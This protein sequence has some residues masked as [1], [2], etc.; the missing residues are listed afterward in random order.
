[1][2]PAGKSV[3]FRIVSKDFEIQKSFPGR[4]WGVIAFSAIMSLGLLLS[5]G[6]GKPRVVGVVQSCKL[7]QNGYEL[8]LGSSNSCDYVLVQLRALLDAQGKIAIQRDGNA[9]AT[10]ANR[11]VGKRVCFYGKVE[12]DKDGR[13]FMLVRD[14]NQIQVLR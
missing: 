4:S 6:C 12:R 7:A 8:S 10:L 11:F 9:I 14:R 2:Q 3:Y 13:S 1:L 5:S